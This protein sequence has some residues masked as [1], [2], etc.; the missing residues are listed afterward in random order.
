MRIT[1]CVPP[2]LIWHIFQTIVDVLFLVVSAYVL[3]SSH[4]HWLLSN[5]LNAT[6]TMSLKSLNFFNFI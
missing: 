3:N 6:I 4:G 1:S 2:P 5:A